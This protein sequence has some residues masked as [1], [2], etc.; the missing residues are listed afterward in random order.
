ME[1][2]SGTRKP[3]T[4]HPSKVEQDRKVRST[5]CSTKKSLKPLENT[6]FFHQVEQLEQVEQYFY[7]MVVVLEKIDVLQ[8]YRGL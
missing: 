6:T 1:Q 2:R 7:E 4:F 5:P 8:E 3:L